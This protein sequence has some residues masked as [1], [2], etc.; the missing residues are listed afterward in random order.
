MPPKDARKGKKTPTTLENLSSIYGEIED[1]DTSPR[2]VSLT[3]VLEGGSPG[4]GDWP[5]IAIYNGHIVLECKW[6]DGLVLETDSFL[7]DINNPYF[8]DTA[9]DKP[10]VLLLR[11]VSGKGAKDPD[12]LLNLDNRAG[13]TV[14]MF[15]LILGEDE[16]FITVPL[17]FL[18]TGESTSCKVQVHAKVKGNIETIHKVPLILTL[19][20]AHCIPISKDGT[21]Y[22]AAIGLDGLLDQSAVNF[23]LSLSTSAATKIMW[24]SASNGGQAANTLFNISNQDK[25]IP[26][27]F[28]AS[29]NEECNSAYW[30]AMKRVLVNPSVLRERLSRPLL[31]EVAGVPRSGKVDVRGRYM[32]FIDA[33]VL[34]EPGQCGVTICAKLLFFKENELPGNV[35]PLLELPPTSAKISAR[36]TDIVIDAFGH[37]AYIVLRFDLIEP[38]TPKSKIAWL[39]ESIGFIPPEGPLVPMNDLE[40]NAISEDT[41]VD[42]KRVCKECGA[43]AVH[44][45][46]S[47]LACRGVVPMNQGIKRTAA[48][49]LLMRVR[50][51]I[52]QFP[53]GECSYIDWQDT[54][55][56]QHAACRRAVTSSFEPQP[57]PLRLPSRVAAARCRLAGDNTMADEHMK[58]NLKVAGSHPRSLLSKALRCLEKKNDTDARNYILQALSGQSRNRFLLWL[59]GAQEFDKGPEATNAAA[60]AFRLAVKGDFS[61]GTT[62]A[63]GWA[64]LHTFYHFNENPYAAFVAIQKMRKSYELPR[65]WKKFLQRWLETSGEEEVFWIPAVV[66]PNNPLLLA[67]TLFLC[68]RCYVF[69]ER[70]LQCVEMG[71]ATRGSRFGLISIISP[72]LY[73]I[74][75]ASFLLRHELDKALEVTNEGIKRFGP[76]AVLSQMRLS[77]L[78]CKRGWDGECEKAL[79]E[80]EKAGAELCPA[81]LLRAAIGNFKIDLKVSLQRAARAH[82][83]APCAHS[84]LIISRIYMKLGE[85]ILSERWASAAVKFEP[86]LSDGWAVLALLAMYQRNLDKARAMLRTAKQVGFISSDIQEEVNK[87]I[88]ITKLETLPEALQKKICFCEYF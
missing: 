36:E 5:F 75:A 71:C 65:E 55:T 24:A 34:L 76:S 56:A 39:Y 16:I 33:R 68:L 9:A 2:S 35:R 50:A 54:V 67:A 42:V 30:N 45:E 82:K 87:V 52:K 86:L 62:N 12:P 11:T 47:G 79:L 6:S 28:E 46:L 15:P 88:E 78:T 40:C 25:F 48:N 26:P 21:V 14:D 64:A 32:G 7:A 63:I 37:N 38:L 18:T 20:S 27:D 53:P 1:I 3:L 10:L 70:L 84:G 83:I 58:T 44:K 13:A 60:A 80:A 59:F 41:M 22:V 61:E 51:M 57:P 73:Y 31:I 23:G 49:R 19:I 66:A 69:S 4:P 81:V 8:Q 77:C 29:N 17:V 72:D 43:L 74:R 85:E